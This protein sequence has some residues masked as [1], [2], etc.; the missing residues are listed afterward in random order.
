MT[1]REI[2]QAISHKTISREQ[3]IIETDKAIS[4]I[5]LKVENTEDGLLYVPI[6]IIEFYRE[7]CDSG[8]NYRGNLGIF[9][10]TKYSWIKRTLKKL[11]IS[12]DEVFQLYWLKGRLVSGETELLNKA[13]QGAIPERDTNTIE[14][15]KEPQGQQGMTALE[16]RKA[17]LRGELSKEQGL[18]ELKAMEF[19]INAILLKTTFSWGEIENAWDFI[20]EPDDDYK[21]GQQGTRRMEV[22]AELK[23]CLEN[24]TPEEV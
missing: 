19:E 17:I 15:D 7:W 8:M 23:T 2:E 10:A 1:G 24:W 6:D 14:T 21:P 9:K 13:P 4:E 11:K 16:I 20:V 18:G 12:L 5:E 3:V 22:N